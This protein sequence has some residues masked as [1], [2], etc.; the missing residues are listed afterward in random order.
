[1]NLFYFN[2][3]LHEKRKGLTQIDNR[4]AGLSFQIRIGTI[5]PGQNL[6]FIFLWGF[7]ILLRCLYDGNKA[8][9]EDIDDLD[10]LFELYKLADKVRLNIGWI[11]S[12][13]ISYCTDQCCWAI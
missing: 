7:D 8:V 10:Q 9:V 1:M 3:F 6:N 13:W 5:L 12:F 2:T 11:W 4:F